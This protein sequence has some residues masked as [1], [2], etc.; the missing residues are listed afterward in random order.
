MTDT[1]LTAP[2]PDGCARDPE[3]YEAGFSDGYE[4][5]YDD[6]YHEGR[7]DRLAPILAILDGVE[8]DAVDLAAAGMGDPSDMKLIKGVL[9][10]VRQRLTLDPADL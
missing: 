6:G 3:A 8:Q 5:G 9:D 7:T 2:D 1:T 4:A 10:N